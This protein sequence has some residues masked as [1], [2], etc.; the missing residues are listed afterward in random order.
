M[1][2]V[3][4]WLGEL[5]RRVVFASFSNWDW[6]FVYYYLVRFGDCSRFGHSPLDMTSDP[7]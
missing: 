6:V 7:S 3:K 4:Q 2:Q 5:G 1:R